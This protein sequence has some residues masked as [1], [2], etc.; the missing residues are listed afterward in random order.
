MTRSMSGRTTESQPGRFRPKE[1]LGDEPYRVVLVGPGRRGLR[2]NAPAINAVEGLSL[3][4][5]VDHI[6]GAGRPDASQQWP[7][8]RIGHHLVTAIDR[9]KPHLAIVATPHDSHVSIGIELLG[10]GVPTI[11]EKPLA[12]TSDELSRLRKA[13]DQY[14]TPLAT[15][16][17]M[18]FAED[19]QAFVGKLE[20]LRSGK[21]RIDATVASY[22]GLAYKGGS[23]RQSKR[24]SGGGVLLDLGYHYLDLLCWRLGPPAI[25]EV[26]LRGADR[27]ADTVEN[28]AR[29]V[30][31]FHGG[32]VIAELNLRASDTESPHILVAVDGEESVQRV[33]S[34]LRSGS[35]HGL[36]S[37]TRQLAFLVEQ[38]FLDGHGAWRD[39]LLV[40][41]TVLKA[42]DEI[43]SRARS[44]EGAS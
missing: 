23:W 34:Q 40:Q 43:Y 30:L 33:Y 31:S 14:G 8:A 26:E 39:D 29:V 36:Q 37:M 21:I 7:D 1:R 19:F 35:T 24:R 22:Q 6:D 27:G 12:R 18:R 5:V 25:H 3:A 13:C 4:A 44:G 11:I 42:I 16:Q 2:T 20:A 38:G 15:V 41:A 28:G 17:S 9:C 10:Q 32:G